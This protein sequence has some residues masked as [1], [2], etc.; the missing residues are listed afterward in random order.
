MT[1]TCEYVIED[2]KKDIKPALQIS[3]AI[4]AAAVIGYIIGTNHSMN[5]IEVKAKDIN[6]DDNIEVILNQPSKIYFGQEKI[7]TQHEGV[8]REVTDLTK[9]LSRAYQDSLLQSYQ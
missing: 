1:S 8:Y 9:E 2:I 6:N 4:G 7:Y 5:Q 3:A